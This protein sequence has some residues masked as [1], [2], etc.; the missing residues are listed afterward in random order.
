M[1]DKGKQVDIPIKTK[2]EHIKDT[3]ATIQADGPFNVTGR[4]GTF[5]G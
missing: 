1:T 2:V 3:K 4:S 5:W